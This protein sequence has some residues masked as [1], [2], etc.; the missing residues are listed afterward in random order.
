PQRLRV[1]EKALLPSSPFRLS[2]S[3]ELVSFSASAPILPSSPE[4]FDSAFLPLPACLLPATQLAA[5]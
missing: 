4:R 1:E 3:I 2:G 5:V